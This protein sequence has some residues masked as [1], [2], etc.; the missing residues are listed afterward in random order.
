MARGLTAPGAASPGSATP[1]GPTL[2]TEGDG[3]R[4]GPGLAGDRSSGN[5]ANRIGPDPGYRNARDHA[6]SVT[7]TLTGKLGRIGPV[8]APYTRKPERAATC[9]PGQES[10]M[11]LPSCDGSDSKGA[12]G[13][14]LTP[15]EG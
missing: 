6:M 12:C 2:R 14:D 1:G 8:G 5:A 11:P 4:F 13:R 7:P 10:A 3:A 15:M 9:A